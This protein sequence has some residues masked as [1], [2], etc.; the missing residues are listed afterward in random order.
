MKILHHIGYVAHSMDDVYSILPSTAGPPVEL[1]WDTEQSNE[2]AIFEGAGAVKWF[3]V[4]VPTGSDSTVAAYL[5]KRGAGFHHLAFQ[6]SS[7]EDELD[8]YLSKPGSIVLGG[9]QLRVNSF[10]GEIRTQFLVSNGI[11]TELVE[12]LSE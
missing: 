4:L 7:I 1:I 12:V 10:G 2:I 5:R 3:E 6:V 8:S 9:F 11:I